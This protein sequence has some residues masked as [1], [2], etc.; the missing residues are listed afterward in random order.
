MWTSSKLCFT[1]Y[2]KDTCTSGLDVL[3]LEIL[4]FEKH[5]NLKPYILGHQRG[6]L[7]S[8]FQCHKIACSHPFNALSFCTFVQVGTN[9][10]NWV[11]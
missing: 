9:I 11:P 5:E 10:I 3:R 8:T 7:A 6:A 4:I 1:C 2:Y